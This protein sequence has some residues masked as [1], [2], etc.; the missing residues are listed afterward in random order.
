MS[1]SLIERL[2]IHASDER[3]TAFSRSTMREVL[4]VLADGGKGEAVTL[5][6][7]QLLEALD[8][9][10][11]D[12]PHD[13]DQLECEVTIQR[14]EGHDGPGTY[15]WLTEYPEEG[16]TLLDGKAAPQA[17]CAPQQTDAEALYEAWQN[18]IKH[19]DA[20][21][22]CAPRE[23]QPV[24][25]EYRNQT[26]HSF[27]THTDPATYHP[28][29]RAQFKDFRALAYATPTPERA[30]ADTS[31]AK[32][33][34]ASGA[35]TYDQVVMLCETN[36]VPLPVEFIEW[37]AEKMTRAANEALIAAGASQERADA[38]KDE[39]LTLGKVLFALTERQKG[40]VTRSED[41][42]VDEA[43]A[44]LAANKEPK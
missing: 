31:G 10:A 21:A 23:A 37:V 16:A 30:D 3:N 44:I 40:N 19:M 42:Y 12:G 29:V 28:D 20:Q 9:V 41:E 15:C 7:A 24:A 26:G 25:W 43:R 39:A 11:P 5:T 38:G 1:E 18:T 22:E 13:A 32:P 6:G 4:E 34:D 17:E 33:E 8:F 27:L 36:G 2:R 35:W 14:G